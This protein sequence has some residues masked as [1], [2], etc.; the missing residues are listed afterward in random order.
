MKFIKI[1]ITLS[2]LVTLLFSACSDRGNE[3]QNVKAVMEDDRIVILI[4]DE[5]FSSYLFGEEHKYPFFYPL[6]GPVSGRSVTAWDQEP[7]PH[8]SSLYISLDWVRSENVERGN[9]WQPRHELDTGQVMSR[10]PQIIE[11]NGKKVILQDE[12]DWIVPSSGSHQLRDIRTVTI[13]APSPSIRLMDFLFEFEILKDLSIGPTGHSFFSARM[14]PELAVGDPDRGPDWA[15]LGTGTIID[16]Y[17]NRN[18][19]GTREQDADWCAYYGEN[20]GVIEGV[21]IIQHSY[22]PYYPAPWFNRDYGFMSPTPFA[23]D[24]DPIELQAG[25]TLTFRYRTV[26]FSGDPEEIEIDAWREDFVAQ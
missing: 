12:T 25:T 23:F 5:E 22:N 13:W 1:S 17:G 16:S 20:N 10:N 24:D 4:N 26:I 2:V 14:R 6:N 18:E 15:H 8:H 19:E 21:A 9:Y 3:S 11:S 7:Y